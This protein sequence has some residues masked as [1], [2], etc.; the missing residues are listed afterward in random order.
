MIID[1]TQL[2]GQCACGRTHTMTT[3]LVVIEAGCM[4]QLDD[5]CERVGLAGTRCVV[6]D[7]NTFHARGLVRPHAALEIV[8]D[9][10]DLHA[11]EHATGKILAALQGHAF[12]YFCAIGA[13]TIHDAVRY[14]AHKMDSVFVACPTA[15]SVDGF[16]STV[17]AMTWHGNKTT[18]PG[19]APRLVLAD[20]DV[21]CAAP[22]YLALSGVGDILG[23]YTSLADWKIAAA[24]T[25]EYFC[26]RIES[27][28]RQ[29]VDGVRAC[30][31]A[32]SSGSPDAFAQLTHAL[33][34]SGLSMQLMGNSRPASGAEHHISHLIEM[35]PPVLRAHSGALHGEKVGVGATI[36]ADAYHRLARHEDITP[37]L[38]PYTAPDTAWLTKCFGEGLAGEILRENES[39]C[40][41]PVAPQAI[42]AAW[43]RICDY[44]AEIP[45]AQALGALLARIGAKHTLADI[46]VGG[47]LALLLLELSPYVRNRLT[48]ARALRMVD[49][50]AL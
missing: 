38:R 29:A 21:I 18:L 25:G 13:G 30:C 4:A 49:G 43:P 28:T 50:A 35:A 47:D 14:C 31:E 36:I 6:Y 27:L 48:L 40:L 26:P 11:D 16:C 24:L 20:L 23:K 17:S 32:L 46:E 37:Y 41:A 44:I 7:S 2:A 39:D 45:S 15:A 12:D 34:L 9:A 1:S 33:L 8:L 5:Y 10:G 3:E 42:A 22:L 19:V